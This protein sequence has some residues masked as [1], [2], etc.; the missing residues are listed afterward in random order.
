MKD[1]GRNPLGTV[2]PAAIILIC[3]MGFLFSP[4]DPF[5]VD[6]SM[7][8]L[9]PT[10]QFPFGTDHMGRCILSRILEGG[11][12]TLGIVLIGASIVFVLGMIMGILFGQIKSGKSFLLDSVLNAVTALPPIA[13]L[14]VFIGAWGNGVFTMIFAV[15][16]SLLLRLIKLVKSKTEIELTKAYVLSAVAAGVPKPKLLLFHVAPNVT[17][18]ALHYIC[19][20]CADLIMVITGFSFIGLGLGDNVID[21]GMM[22]SESRNFVLTYPGIMMYPV[23]FIL[24]STFSLNLLARGIEKRGEIHA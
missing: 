20:S 8:F 1:V 6:M 15:T 16:I 12:I 18:E 21:W 11:K 2:L 4:N 7:R 14:I 23:A 13:Y 5:H 19:L 9:P 3:M 24:L 17:P 10:M 22:V